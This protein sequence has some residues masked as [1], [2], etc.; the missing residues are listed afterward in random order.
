[1]NNN[2]P[3]YFYK[4]RSILNSKNLTS[5]YALEALFNNQAIFS[6]R[7]NFNDLFDSKINLIKPTPKQLKLL[8]SHLTKKDAAIVSGLTS[9]GKFTPRGDTY[10]S[11]IRRGIEKL[12]DSY[13]FYCVTINP[14]SNLMWSHYADSHHGFC[15]E[16]KSEFLKADKVIY[17]KDI[18]SI[19][20]IDLIKFNRQIISGE[21]IGIN[22]WSALKTKLGNSQKA[23]RGTVYLIIHL[24]YFSCFSS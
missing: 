2:L 11:N 8:K 1:M 4:Y 17:Q 10:L 5:D 9:K 23:I 13:A 14:I 18:P 6:S 24:R 12:L 3:L 22:I 16:F 21:N 15:I 7:K 19:H 20:I